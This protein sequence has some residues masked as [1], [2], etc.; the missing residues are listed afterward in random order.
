MPVHEQLGYDVFNCLDLMDNASFLEE[1][2]FHPGD[3]N[4]RHVSLPA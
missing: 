2:K 3:G 4:V 1:L